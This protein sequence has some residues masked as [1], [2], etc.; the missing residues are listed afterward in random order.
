ML[1]QIL[2]MFEEP[3]L[4]I[5]TAFI[6][7]GSPLKSRS[8][9]ASVVRATLGLTDCFANG[10]SCQTRSAVYDLNKDSARG[11]RFVNSRE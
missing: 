8:L 1:F 4:Q 10:A 5:T 3:C 11:N 9:N 6:R 7:E 2:M